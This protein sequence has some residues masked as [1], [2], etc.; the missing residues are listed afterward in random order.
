MRLELRNNLDVPK[1]KKET[2]HYENTEC[3]GQSIKRNKRFEKFFVFFSFSLVNKVNN[4]VH[5][6]IDYN[7]YIN[8]LLM[9]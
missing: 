4:F 6:G 5:G 7:V 1:Y 9:M 8:N 3:E 2:E